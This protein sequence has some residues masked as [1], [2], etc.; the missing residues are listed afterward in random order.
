MLREHVDKRTG[1]MA[2]HGTPLSRRA[3]FHAPLSVD[4]GQRN[5]RDEAGFAESVGALGMLD[6]LTKLERNKTPSVEHANPASFDNFAGQLVRVV[7]LC[8]LNSISNRALLTR[9]IQI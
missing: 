1:N 9:E 7:L 2:G 6:G 8:Q 5:F 4:L 3:Y